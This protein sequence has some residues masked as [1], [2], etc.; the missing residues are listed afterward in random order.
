MTTVAPQHAASRKLY[1]IA[2][3]L[4][5]GLGATRCRGLVTHFGGVENVF[6]AGLTELEGAGLA[7][8]SAQAIE[9]GK[10]LAAAEEEMIRAASIGAEIVTLDDAA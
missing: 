3:A 7:A 9:T 10:S 6:H 8:A 4:T 5:P 2:L 1:W